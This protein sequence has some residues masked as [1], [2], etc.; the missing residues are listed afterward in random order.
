MRI[1]LIR[2]SPYRPAA[3]EDA[4]KEGLTEDRIVHTPNGSETSC[5]TG[6]NDRRLYTKY[7]QIDSPPVA[8]A[9]ASFSPSTAYRTEN[10]PASHRRRRVGAAVAGRTG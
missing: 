1:D 9:K 7:R 4:V 2:G 10:D 6:G 3:S 8:A 5:I